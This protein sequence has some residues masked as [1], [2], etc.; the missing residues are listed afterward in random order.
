M[1][2]VLVLEAPHFNSVNHWF[3]GSHCYNCKTEEYGK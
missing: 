3:T 2:L 1:I